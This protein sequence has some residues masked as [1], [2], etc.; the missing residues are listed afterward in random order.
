MSHNLCFFMFIATTQFVVCRVFACFATR[1]ET[2]I[3]F[4]IHLSLF[5]IASGGILS[6]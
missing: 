4:Q 6:I 1:G 3:Q 2:I 5:Y